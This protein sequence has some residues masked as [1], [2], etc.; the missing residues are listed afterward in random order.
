MDTI[1]ERI[2]L[3]R[4]DNNLTQ[5]QFSE[6]ILVTQSYLSRIESGKEIPNEKLTKLIALEFNVSTEWLE[7]GIGTKTIDENSSD[8][9]DRAY[10]NEHEEA[11]KTTFN[12]FMEFLQRNNNTAINSNIHAIILEMKAFLIENCSMTNSHTIITFEEITAIILEL[13]LQLKKIHP[14]MKKTDFN[15]LAWICT[16]TFTDSLSKI[17]ELYFNSEI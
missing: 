7:K 17:E 4:T 5:K 1:N 9:F 2:K 15:S 11:L 10:S 3:L 6:R 14:K 8:Y 12:E 13:F 16:T